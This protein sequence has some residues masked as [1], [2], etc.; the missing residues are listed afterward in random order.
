M[1]PPLHTADLCKIFAEKEH[2]YS[3]ARKAERRWGASVSLQMA[4][5]RHESAYQHDV[6]P[7]RDYLLG[8]I[9]WFRSSSAYG[10]AQAQDG[11]WQ[12]YIRVS[13]NKGADRD[14][15]ADAVD[16]ISWYVNQSHKMLG[17]SRKDTFRQYLAYHEGQ[18]GYK[19]GS[20]KSKHQLKR[21]A[22][23]VADTEREYAQQLVECVQ[24][25]AIAKRSWWQF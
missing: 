20:Y 18:G 17:I 23:K 7:P 9:P 4:F 16:F 19:R 25:L 5:L 8:I 11:T 1:K 2:W 14:D 13:G 22:R 6:R 15:F 24:G 10:Y 21:Y 12:W 3:D